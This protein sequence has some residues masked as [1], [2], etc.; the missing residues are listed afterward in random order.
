MVT[1]SINDGDFRVTVGF[2][3]LFYSFA[4]CLH[5]FYILYVLL[6]VLR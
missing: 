5:P 1:Q 2:S 3:T 4:Y 6:H